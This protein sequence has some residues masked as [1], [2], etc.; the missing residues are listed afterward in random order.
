M[1]FAQK[2]IAV[3][4]ILCSGCGSTSA[5]PDV[6]PD[7]LIDRF[8][9]ADLPF[10]IPGDMDGHHDNVVDV[11]DADEDAAG[12]DVSV[13]YE[14]PESGFCGPNTDKPPV[15]PEIVELPTLP[16]LS[17]DGTDIV[18]PEGNRVALR[19]FNLGS[20]LAVEPW[21][22]GLGDMS[23]DELLAAFEARADELGLAGLLE[24]AKSTNF[25]DWL[26]ETKTHRQVIDEWR[27]W[28][29]ANGAGFEGAVADLWSWFDAQP[30]ILEEES[31][32]RFLGRRFGP[33]SAEELRVAFGRAYVTEEDVRRAAAL[34]LNLLRVPV[35][36]QALETE[37]ADGNSY[38]PEGWH[39]LHELAVWA[40]RHKVYLM[41]DLHGAPGGQSTSAHQGL[42]A[43]GQLWT[44]QSCIDKT[45]RLWGDLAA[46]FRGDPHVAIYDLLNEPMNCPDAIAY[47]KVHQAIYKAIRDVDADHIVCVEDGFLSGS[48]LVSPSEMGWENAMFSFHFYP[49]GADT[50][51]S[52]VS[53]TVNE[54]ARIRE[55]SARY[56]CPVL[57]G[58]F[59]AASGRNSG[60]WA[61]EASDRVLELLNSHGIHWT[62][63]TWKFFAD[64]ALW[65]LYHPAIDPWKRVPV[66]DASFDEL[67]AAFVGMHSIAFVPHEG[68]ADVVRSRADDPVL[69]QNL[70]PATP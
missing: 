54:I 29:S 55:L 24:Q 49:W 68:F 26:F 46:Y 15:R 3:A 9:E 56:G 25:F 58:E 31:L 18:D 39:R 47:E 42:A 22:L 28:M 6:I 52:Y 16:F 23:E 61:L 65:G 35:W 38:R 37:L 30:W 70:E 48:K 2:L 34:G 27:A 33:D 41:L 43:G 11:H 69:Q 4:V 51:D 14:L 60:P 66:A 5:L 57:A 67:M 1:E 59:S 45:A 21:V 19:G 40:R 62:V 53:G 36:Y 63:W 64:W 10:D 7:V 13:V 12:S 20:W 17:V 44:N 32:W 8:D 50:A